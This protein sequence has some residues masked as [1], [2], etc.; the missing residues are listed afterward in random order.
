MTV[1]VEGPVRILGAGNGDPAF[2]AKERPA[3]PEENVFTIETFNG[4][5][6]ILIQSA[7]EA[8]DARVRL[9]SPGLPDEILTLR[10]TQ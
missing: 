7:G 10:L 1:R 9:S 4:L 2:R 6:Q 8:G 3:G 5:A